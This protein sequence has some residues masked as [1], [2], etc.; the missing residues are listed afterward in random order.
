MSIVYGW[1]MRKALRELRYKCRRHNADYYTDSAIPDR[2]EAYSAPLWLNLDSLRL[3]YYWTLLAGEQCKS[4]AIAITQQNF[5]MRPAI[6]VPTTGAQI[7]ELMCTTVPL[8]A[9]FSRSRSCVFYVR[10][11][12]D[13]YW[14]DAHVVSRETRRQARV[15][16][17]RV[18]RMSKICWYLSASTPLSLNSLSRC[19]VRDL[20][21]HGLLCHEKA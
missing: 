10:Y 7:A 16:S 12:H 4:D 17:I 15:E 6:R 5:D 20:I 8:M 13:S 9:S 1:M 2:G 21:I 3:E 11:R 14:L 18:H 19:P